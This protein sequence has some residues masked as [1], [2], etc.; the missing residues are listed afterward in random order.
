[1]DIKKA[2]IYTYSNNSITSLQHTSYNRNPL[3]RKCT[4]ILHALKKSEIK[5]CWIP[6]HFGMLGTKRADKTSK[7]SAITRET[8][9]PVTDTLQ[10]V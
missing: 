7:A 2:I 5:L 1:M 3:V 4:E 6:G 9:V 8:L 10:A